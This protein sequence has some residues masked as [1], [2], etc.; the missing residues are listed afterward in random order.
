MDI[1]PNLK[2]T[3][4]TEITETSSQANIATDSKRYTTTKITNKQQPLENTIDNVLIFTKNEQEKQQIVDFYNQEYSTSNVVKLDENNDLNDNDLLNIISCNT[5][6]NLVVDTGRLF[7]DEPL[8]LI[9]DLTNMTSGEIARLNDLLSTPAT[10]NGKA[11]SSSVKITVIIDKNMLT[12]GINKPSAD[13]WRRINKFKFYESPDSLYSSRIASL[14]QANSSVLTKELL[15]TKITNR[16]DYSQNNNP[17]IID[18]A[19]INSWQEALFGSLTLN[20]KGKIYFKKGCLQEVKNNNIVL[21]NAP[22]NNIEFTE[23]LA[24]A[25]HQGGFRANGKWINLPTDLQLTRSSTSE[26]QV[27]ELIKKHVIAAE[28]LTSLA[29]EQLA[30]INS[31]NFASVFADN[32]LHQDVVIATDTFA[33]LTQDCN[34]LLITENLTNDQWL[35]LLT[36]ITNLGDKAPSIIDASNSTTETINKLIQGS[37]NNNLQCKTYQYKTDALAQKNNNSLV[38]QITKDTS[39]LD[40]WQNISLNSQ[41][42]FTFMQKD[43]ELLTALKQGKPVIFYGLES[44]TEILKHF[45]TLFIKP[46]YL[47]LHGNKIQLTNNNITILLAENIDETKLPQLL[48]NIEKTTLTSTPKTQEIKFFEQILAK[49]AENNI[50]LSQDKKTLNEMFVKQLEIEK[51]QDQ[52]KQLLA[53]HYRKA[54]HTIFAKQYRDDPLLYGYLK[55]QIAAIYIDDT[56]QQL[57]NAEAL[58]NWVKE[59]PNADRKL[60]AKDF[61]LLA[62]HCSAR[63]FLGLEK[64]ITDFNFTAMNDNETLDK[65]ANIVLSVI[66]D[67]EKQLFANQFAINNHNNQKI[68]Y[69]NNSIRSALID[70]MLIAQDK[71]KTTDPISKVAQN[72][73]VEVYAI[74]KKYPEKQAVQKIS[75]ALKNIFPIKLLQ[76]EFKDLAYSLITAEIN[77]NR[78]Q[79][80]KKQR[81]ATRITAYPIIFLQGIAGAGKSHMAK[82]VVEN[83]KASNYFDNMPKPLVLSLGPETTTSDLF[84]SQQLQQTENDVH[85][86]FVAGPI[87]NW[88]M[89]DN[90][91]LLILDEAN[92]ALDGVLSPLAGLANKPPQLSYAGKVYP[93]STKHRVIVTGN[94]NNYDGRH[95]DTELSSVMLT[96]HYNAMTNTDLAKLIIEPALTTNLPINTKQEIINSILYLHNEYNKI[97]ANKLNPRDL[98]D[99]IARIN[100]IIVHQD[101]KINLTQVYGLVWAAFAEI[102]SSTITNKLQLTQLFTTYK[103]KFAITTFDKSILT[104]RDTKFKAFFNEL[105][106]NN[107]ELDLSSNAVQKLVKDYWLFLDSQANSQGRRGLWVEGPAGW[108]KDSIL[109]AVLVLWEQHEG[110]ENKFIHITANINQWDKLVNTVKHAMTSGQK[111]VISELNLLPSR[112]LE[113]LFNDVLTNQSNP[114]FML[115]ATVNPLSYS[116][117][118]L[119]SVAFMNR[120]T[121]VKLAAIS[122]GELH[123]ILL[124]KYPD[125]LMMIAWLFGN[126]L[127]LD[128][129]LQ[130]QK[131]PIQLSLANLLETAAKLYNT[132]TSHWADIFQQDYGLAMLMIKDKSDNLDI[133]APIK[134][135]IDNAKSVTPYNKQKTKSSDIESF[136]DITK[137]G[138]LKSTNYFA[139]NIFSMSTYRLSLYKPIVTED[140]V[141][142]KDIQVANEQIE[143][144]YLPPLTTERPIKLET[145]QLLGTVELELFSNKWIALPGISS[146]D[147]CIGISHSDLIELG[148]CPVTRMLVV[149]QKKQK[150][151]SQKIKLDFIIKPQLLSLNDAKVAD[152]ITP[153]VQDKYLKEL[154]DKQIFSPNANA[155]NSIKK[156]QQ[157]KLITDKKLQMKELITW[158]SFF[159]DYMDI[160]SK[161]SDALIDAIRYQTGTC[162][163]RTIIFQILAEYFGIPTIC[164]DNNI[165]MFVEFSLDNQQTWINI[166]LGGA[167]I[168]EVN[169]T[170]QEQQFLDHQQVED[171][172]STQLDMSNT[173]GFNIE[174]ITAK[175]LSNELNNKP[176]QFMRI[177]NFISNRKNFILF[178]K[179][180]FNSNFHQYINSTTVDFSENL[181]K[182]LNNI[183]IIIEKNKG[184]THALTEFIYLFFAYTYTQFQQQKIPHDKARSIL[185]TC[186]PLLENNTLTTGSLLNIVEYLTKDKQYGNRAEIILNKYYSK[187]NNIIN[188]S[189]DEGI[190]INTTDSDL[191][192]PQILDK[193]LNPVSIKTNWSYTST[194]KSPNINRLATKKPAFPVT[195]KHQSKQKNIYVYLG[196]MK[197]YKDL[198]A[199]IFDNAK[200]LNPDNFV[201]IDIYHKVFKNFL[202]WIFRYMSTFNLNCIIDENTNSKHRQLLIHST[203]SGY[204]KVNQNMLNINMLSRASHKYATPI[205]SNKTLVS[206]L[207]PSR[208]KQVFGDSAILI[209]PDIIT[210]CFKEYLDLIIENSQ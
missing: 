129:S 205:A 43:T 31:H 44:N 49:F 143:A 203:N 38:Y 153:P 83:L 117:R 152:Y 204:I 70:A 104:A 52:A 13:L 115:F 9:I 187:L 172:T 121:Q 80:R 133:N 3:N 128:R 42:N 142:L 199:D 193:F 103:T 160:T 15:L 107:L 82:T 78:K 28:N 71:L 73:A 36:R 206:E 125:N 50:E 167:T 139:T 192:H 87:L 6:G 140:G 96:L 47:L 149:R 77:S 109:N 191:S 18:F 16:N 34:Y 190:L 22:W 162:R 85:T 173:I 79:T 53:I 93:L 154:L 30:I 136:N 146:H 131:A 181:P 69:Y 165:H 135:S 102:L 98:Q 114:N 200:N 118:E 33:E 174:A 177:L 208:I 150:D 147:E 51:Q 132:D 105:T 108:G 45:E 84:G 210:E 195:K 156:L 171:N 196:E 67:D 183:I 41:E 169:I 74:S 198:C 113:G 35:K 2:A 24:T 92:L 122:A 166:N 180:I 94:P 127:D 56:N 40:M 46:S 207:N 72:F 88:V 188:V 65:L 61:W 29:N 12:T 19:T 20:D 55:T 182:I 57:V 68:I 179:T 37:L 189:E 11:I 97:I 126:Y 14:Q 161:G 8:L 184:F 62:R 112:Y 100:R 106:Y 91:P 170:K 194:G 99:I 58:V 137:V 59:N 186:L 7:N 81:L 32:K 75:K 141:S 138:N 164:I 134:I 151:T 178:A 120:M 123:K 176:D 202:T 163:H 86:E 168:Q 76:T 124:K 90:P 23:T 116:N 145:G 119:L 111:L 157:I 175:N 148:R 158:A 155:N 17:T 5:A 201:N 1:R 27:T 54:A 60:L 144:I 185:I 159:K 95:M 26:Q 63:C 66:A 48:Q 130:Q 64:N 21:H 110:C 209:T 197:S 101:K 4:I 25:L 89:N 39:W 10:C